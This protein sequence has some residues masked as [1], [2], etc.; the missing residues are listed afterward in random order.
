MDLQQKVLWNEGLFLTPHHF[1]QWDRHLEA[2][3]WHRLRAIQPLSY[4]FT[5]LK[6]DEDAL[7]VGDL[8][9]NRCGG[10]MQDGLPFSAPDVDQVPP[11]RQLSGIFDSKGR[12]MV[13]LC[14]NTDNG[15]GW[16]EETAAD[17]F[18]HAFSENKNF[19]LGINIIF[20]ALTH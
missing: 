10:V 15:D 14:H 7:A 18:F 13:M 3:L 19:P 5:D 16:E 8:V 2:E 12:L 11:T 6:I 9:V 4:G 20:Y 1:Q 17:W